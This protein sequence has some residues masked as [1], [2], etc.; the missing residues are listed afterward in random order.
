MP[1]NSSP[2]GG[3][4]AEPHEPGSEAITSLLRRTAAGDRQAEAR[5]V[6]TIYGE[7]RGLARRELVRWPASTTPATALAHE[8]F[9]RLL[10]SEREW[11]NRRYFFG[12]CARALHE[13]LIEQARRRRREERLPTSLPAPGEP[14]LEDEMEELRVNLDRLDVIQARAAEVFRLHFLVGKTIPEIS[15]VLACGHATVERDLRFARTWLHERIRQ[16]TAP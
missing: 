16:T 15:S 7:L 4:P 2:N 10:R 9:D 13:I 5:L 8:L 14:L 12:A 1:P 3:F 6:A 11:P